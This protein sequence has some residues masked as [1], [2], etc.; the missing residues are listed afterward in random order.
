MSEA[1][2]E[3]GERM[4]DKVFAVASAKESFDYNSVGV[5]T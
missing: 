2:T 4:S 1:S 3:A 5:S